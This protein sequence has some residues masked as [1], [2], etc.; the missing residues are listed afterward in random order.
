MQP[1]LEMK[2]LDLDTSQPSDATRWEF[3]D[4][5]LVTWRGGSG[6]V[7]SYPICRFNDVWGEWYRFYA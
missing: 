6:E 3:Y 7:E 5:G 2:Y 1:G 4:A